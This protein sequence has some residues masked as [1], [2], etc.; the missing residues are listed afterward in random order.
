MVAWSTRVITSI[1]CARNRLDDG[2]LGIREAFTGMFL[3][4]RKTQIYGACLFAGSPYFGSP[5]STGKRIFS[6][7]K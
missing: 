1:W 4:P 3:A 5:N 6:S 2:N 7:S